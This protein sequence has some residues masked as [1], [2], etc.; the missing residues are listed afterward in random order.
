MRP[1][2]QPRASKIT[3]Q[4][5]TTTDDKDKPVACYFR[6]LYLS[7][8]HLQDLNALF[9][10]NRFV[11]HKSEAFKRLQDRGGVTLDYRNG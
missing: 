9:A 6:G 11:V 1:L 8:E 7:R 10:T 4:R 2:L 3:T 5:V